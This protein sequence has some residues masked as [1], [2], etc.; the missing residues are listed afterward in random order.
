M[1][2]RK[3]I[4]LS[5]LLAAG[6]SAFAQTSN[7]KKAATNIQEYEKFRTAGTP[8]FGEKFLNTA[9]E[10]IDLAVVNE[11]T[12]DNADAWTYYSLIYSNLATDKKNAEDAKKAD[13]AIKKAKELDKEGKNKENI[14]IAEQILYALNFNQGVAFWEASDFK[15]AYNS[16]DHALT[17]APGDTTLTYY[18][19]IA[20]IQTADYPKGIEK[21]KQLLD[22]RDYSQHKTVVLDLPKLYLNL[23]DTTSALEYAALAAK[24]YPNDNNAVTQNIELNLIV[25]NEGKIVSDIEAQILKD[26]GNKTLY[27]YLGLAL[28]AS[29]KTKEAF[30]AYKK[31][32]AIDP[33][34]IDANLNAAVT[35]INST[36]EEI[37]A[38]N[39]D[40]TISNNQYATKIEAL[41]QQIKP[42]ETYFLAVL[43]N[44]PKNDMALRGLKSLYD[45]LQNEEK[46]KEI[47]NRI[48]AL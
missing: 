40:K 33:N 21:Y 47:Q 3:T 38:L 34:Y 7:V 13:A 20:A 9:K 31:A 35:L 5:A 45:F 11:K 19:A 46:S 42:S 43:Q 23:N 1:N 4:I 14:G 39:E 28:S 32:L 12:K 37:Q 25:G 26:S 22:K 16:F 48:D 8:Q 36:R 27:Y 29:G 24:E 41:K 17:Y 30:E 18:A 6:S 10:A 44:D 15:N 2:F